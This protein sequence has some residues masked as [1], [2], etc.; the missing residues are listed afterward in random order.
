MFHYVF[1]T[2]RQNTLTLGTLAHFRH[3]PFYTFTLV[4]LLYYTIIIK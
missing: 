4:V 2:N 3:L 1:Y